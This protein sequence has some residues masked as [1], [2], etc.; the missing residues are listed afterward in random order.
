MKIKYLNNKNFFENY[1]AENRNLRKL[2][3]NFCGRS[4]SHFLHKLL[5]GHPNIITFHHEYDIYVYKN[6]RNFFEKKKNIRLLSEFLRINLK[7]DFKNHLNIFG[8][9]KLN[10]NIDQIFEEI[11]NFVNNNNIE[12][13]NFDLLIDIF[14]LAHAKVNINYLVSDDPYILMQTHVP[15]DL[16]E[17]NFYFKN[18]N[19]YKLFIIIRDPVKS[20]D[21]HCYHHLEEHVVPPKE[22]LFTRMLYLFYQSVRLLREKKYGKK[23]FLL[24]FE[25]LHLKS[26][27]KINLICKEL[28]INFDE[29]L[30]N[31]TN[32][33]QD[34]EHIKK[35]SNEI[36]KNFRQ[37][38]LPEN[39]IYLS[40][41][42]VQMIE[43][44][45]DDIFKLCHYQK[46]NTNKTNVYY[47]AFKYLIN[48]KKEY[49]QENIDNL[50]KAEF[51]NSFLLKLFKIRKYL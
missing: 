21:S 26:F 16:E 6:L 40:S 19:L 38:S 32:L 17:E 3:I 51:C 47:L 20:I 11:N 29:V 37:I 23:V 22:T 35:K 5:D 43:T 42:Q 33:G 36:F 13:Y 30:L 46:R 9:T 10:L 4:G 24:K 45:F 8:S 49:L 14:Y 50:I 41:I 31:E 15:F 27:D 48:I 34:V 1:L 2:N 18:V 25:D 28:N 39:L 44:T 7:R 12:N